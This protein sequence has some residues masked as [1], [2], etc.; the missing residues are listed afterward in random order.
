MV[1]PYSLVIQ[2]LTHRTLLHTTYFNSLFQW[3]PRARRELPAS[4]NRMKKREINRFRL[5]YV[6]AL[7]IP[8]S[9][10]KLIPSGPCGYL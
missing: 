6:Q 4:R 5:L 9:I 10:S 3:L 2:A 1:M 8:K 7:H